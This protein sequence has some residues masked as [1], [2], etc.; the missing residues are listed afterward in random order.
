MRW[1]EGAEERHAAVVLPAIYGSERRP[2]GAAIGIGYGE[3]GDVGE[4]AEAAAD[5][6]TVL[7]VDGGAGEPVA[8]VD[9]E[10]IELVDVTRPRLVELVEVEVE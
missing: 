9:D 4:L 6:A 5:G 7:M 3:V 10:K 2:E 1:R 8:G